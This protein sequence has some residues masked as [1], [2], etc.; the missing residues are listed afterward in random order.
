[1]SKRWLSGTPMKAVNT[2]CLGVDKDQCAVQF[3]QGLL[4]GVRPHQLAT[5]SFSCRSPLPSPNIERLLKF[6][7]EHTGKSCWSMSL[8]HAAEGTPVQYEGLEYS[9]VQLADGSG[10]RWEVTFADGKHKSGI[11]PVSRA[12]AEVRPDRQRRCGYCSSVT[13]LAEFPRWSSRRYEPREGNRRSVS[14]IPSGSIFPFVL[15]DI[16]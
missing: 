13:L 3:G 10:W 15:V 12:A 2:G 8:L 4:S 11:T 14:P 1:M 6:T 9:V 5:S 7:S 16:G